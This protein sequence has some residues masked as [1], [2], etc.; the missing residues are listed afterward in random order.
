MPRFQIFPTDR[1]FSSG[2]VAPNAADVLDLVHRLSLNEAEVDRDGVYAFSVRLDGD[3]L[4]CI[5]QR[6]QSGPTEAIECPV[7]SEA[8]ESPR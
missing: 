2:F 3:G 8:P 6:D 4:W 7:S 5:Y 1:S